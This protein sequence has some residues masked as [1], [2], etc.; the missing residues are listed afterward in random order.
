M[1]VEYE[2]GYNRAK[3]EIDD[4][5]RKIINLCEKNSDYLWIE[6]GSFGYCSLIDEIKEELE[7]TLEE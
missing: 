1:N 7:K 6:E 4:K 3:K 5:I 2:R